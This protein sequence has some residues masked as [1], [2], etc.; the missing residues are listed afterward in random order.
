M[1]PVND[2]SRTS[3][4]HRKTIETVDR[5]IRSGHWIHGPEHEAFENELSTLIGTQYAVGVANGTDA[6]EIALRAVGCV[7]GSRVITVANAGGYASIAASIIG[8]EIYYCDIDP[9]NLVMDPVSLLPLL[10]RNIDVVV[11]THLFGNVAPIGLI[12]EMC[13]PFGIRV[14]EDCAQGIGAMENGK[15]LGSIGDIGTFSF[16]PTKNL[17]AIGDAGAL[18]TNNLEY[19]QSARQLRQ[20][21]WNHKYHIQLPGGRNSRLDEIQAAILR[22][23]LPGLKKDNDLRRQ[24]LKRFKKATSG[25]KIRLVTSNSEDS[26]A[27]LAVLI[28]SSTAAR[29]DFRDYLLARGI[30]SDIHYPR[31]DTDQP[32]LSLGPMNFDLP[33]SRKAVGLI[34][35]IPL[36]PGLTE[37]E[38]EE[39]CQAIRDYV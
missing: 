39:I 33:V 7:P 29:Q 32:G 38:I 21:G 9:I 16:Y 25:T 24:I 34:V 27:H 37:S 22:C 11:V 3:M 28:L 35:T 19:A 17:G 15:H 6:L 2:L 5:V 14:I 12:A 18:T 26:A 31:L 1:I 23:G 13:E 8:C 30:Q 10:S 4:D 36:F 20:Y